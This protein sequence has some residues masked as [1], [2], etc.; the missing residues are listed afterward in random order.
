MK[1][2]WMLRMFFAAMGGSLASLFWPLLIAL[3]RRQSNEITKAFGLEGTIGALSAAPDVPGPAFFRFAYRVVEVVIFPF[4]RFTSKMIL[5]LVIALLIA[6]VSTAL[7]FAAFLQN[8]ETRK[9][10]E[11]TGLLAYFGAFN[12]G[13][14]AATLV[15]EP[16]KS[17]ASAKP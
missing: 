5:F 7:G 6:L 4:V 17:K 14:T 16:L 8:E 3:W 13:F 9:S 12:Y 1:T 15:S 10:L 11:A 2:D